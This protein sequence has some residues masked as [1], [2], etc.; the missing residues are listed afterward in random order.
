MSGISLDDIARANL[1]LVDRL[2]RDFQRDPQSVDERW[3][4]LFSGYEFGLA[5]SGGASVGGAVG[6]EPR[7]V[8][9]Y[10]LVHT[11]RELGHAVAN[12]DPL[13]HS[14]R[15]HPLLELGEFGFKDSDLDQSFSGGSFVGIE[16]TTLRELLQALR[17]TYCRSIG[18]EFLSI[19]DKTQRD[20]LQAHMEPCRNRP[21]LDVA[22]RQGLLRRLLQA[23][24]FEQFIHAKYVG[25]KRFSLEGG[26]ALIPLLDAAIEAVAAEGAEEIVIGMPHRGRL[27]VLA[28]TLRKP[29]AN[30]L[31]EFEGLFYP[32]DLQGAGDVKYHLGFSYDLV[33]AAGKKVHLSLSYNPSHLE[34][35]N[36]VVEG[37]VRAKQEIRGDKTR[38]KVVPVLMHGDAAFAGQGVVYETMM[39]CGIDGYATGGTIHVI[40]NNQIGFTTNPDESRSTYYASNLA[41]VIN[42]PVFHVNADD[43]E[44]VVHA[45]TLAAKFRQRF[46]WDVVIDLI[47]YRRHGH[48]ELDD[49]TFTQPQM[50]AEIKKHPTVTTLYGQQLQQEGALDA[51][52][53][54]AIKGEIRQSLDTAHEEAKNFLPR[55]QQQAFTG[56]WANFTTQANDWSA[57]TRVPQKRLQQIAKTLTTLPPD[58]T[59]HPRLPQQLKQMADMFKAGEALNWQ[60]GE[61]LAYGSLLLE[62]VPVRLSGQDCRRG[63]FSHRHAALRD[64]ANGKLYVPLNHIEAKQ[65]TFEVYNSPLNEAALLGFE[66]GYASV[67]PNRV[68]IWEAQ[69]G[70]FANGAQVVI[71]QFLAAGESKWQRGNGLVLFLP[72]GY[73]GQ[74]PEHSSA[75]P[76]RFLQLCAENN[77]Q[78]VNCSTPAQ[79]FHA[80]RRQAKR[81]FRKP[82][83]VF[84]PKSLL[85]HP[86]AI[87]PLADF[88]DRDFQSVIDDVAVKNKNKVK[89]L[90][91][92]TGR[93]YYA[94][95]EY[96][97]EA[98]KD[99]V[100]IVRIEELYPFP[101]EQLKQVASAYGNVGDICWVQEEPWNQGFWHFVSTRL[102]I[103]LAGKPEV[104]Y[105]GRK[106][107]ASPATGSYKVHKA[108]EDEL[109]RLAFAKHEGQGVASKRGP[110]TVKKTAVKAAATK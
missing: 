9:I 80:V 98:D 44:A 66:W 92:C 93:I 71:D 75:R 32:G 102:A 100:A 84:T 50:Y 78:V 79:I 88:S 69:F 72:H 45:A 108:E 110:A 24:M 42:A 106:G 2:Y 4:L 25:A 19:R 105:V 95:D 104:R 33:T 23:E 73:E 81:N 21:Q 31:A 22:T 28:H 74:G 26:E 38:R 94:L 85:R 3:R 41:K 35:I 17:D 67:D 15:Q 46:G 70:D 36:P 109:L 62:G 68:V 13:G 8:G 7:L 91:L 96:R 99:E 55:K 40:V 86:K 54:A 10:D 12:L 29:Y 103:V 90:L 65:A 49:P 83:V 77:M 60:A 52:G 47:C 43:P 20:W 48:N 5:Q 107:A 53:V 64:A 34:I 57:E 82:L 18:V 61:L 56:L 76:E 101:D 37:M 59:P 30:I 97:Q 6:S 16:R 89:R 14:P 87:S 51:N 11:Y 1:D 27:N 63:T 39:F 58:F